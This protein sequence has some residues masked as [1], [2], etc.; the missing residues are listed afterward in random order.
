MIDPQLRS[1]P[2]PA[3]SLHPRLPTPHTTP[4]ASIL[5]PHLSFSAPLMAR[6]SSP[7][8]PPSRQLSPSPSVSSV[9]LFGEPVTPRSTVH[10]LS[11]WPSASSSQALPPPVPRIP[12]THSLDD[13]IRYWKEGDLRQGLTVPLY[14]WTELYKP[15]EYRAEAQKLTMIKHV[16]N[17]YA[18]HCKE[19][20]KVFEDRFPGLRN[21]YGKLVKAVRNARIERGESKRR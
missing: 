16:W 21:Q 2:L 15:S 1:T 12:T 5:T 3:L 4:T 11:A 9:D 14:R 7:S 19:D 18:V 13:V 6:P 20:M 8:P 10:R 17:E